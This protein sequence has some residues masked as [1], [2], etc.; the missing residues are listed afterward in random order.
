MPPRVITNEQV[1]EALELVITQGLNAYEAGRK[2]GVSGQALYKRLTVLPQYREFMEHKKVKDIENRAKVLDMGRT[3]YTPTVIANELCLDAG[4]TRAWLLEAG[5]DTSR[6]GN[7][8]GDNID[9]PACDGV[10]K[11]QGLFFWMC[12]ICGSEWWPKEAPDNPDDW[13]RPWRIRY[14]DGGVEMLGLAKRLF[15][16]EYTI[17]EICDELNKRGIKTHSGKEWKKGTLYGY[18]VRRGIVSQGGDRDRIEEII[19]VMAEKGYF[20]REIAARLNGDGLMN[21]YGK[22]WSPSGISKLS[23]RIGVKLKG[24]Q[25]IY[26]KSGCTTHPWANDETARREQNKAWRRSRDVPSL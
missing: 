14:E 25:A 23:Q 3:G 9:C 15:E 17:Q 20:G 12:D 1:G 4:T 21:F 22:K 2:L 5:I 16:E 6:M 11:K 7:D 24:R 18:L 26:K 8:K 10:M 19:R 13:A